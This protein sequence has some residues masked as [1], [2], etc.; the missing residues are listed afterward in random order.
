MERVNI[1]DKLG[2]C[3]EVLYKV[4]TILMVSTGRANPLK[5]L[6]CPRSVRCP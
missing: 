2:K 6:D 3:S 1:V 4:P 5:P